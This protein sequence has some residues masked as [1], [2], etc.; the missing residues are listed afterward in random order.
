[1]WKEELVEI[2]FSSDP[3]K[4]DVKKA[5]NL[6]YMNTPTSLYRYRD[7]DD[8]HSLDLL[9]T[10]KLLLSK[11]SRFNDPFD[12]A[13]K[14]K[15]S[16]SPEYIGKVL[17]DESNLDYF[18][19]HNISLKELKK[20]GRKKD[21]LHELIKR[22]VKNNNP[23]LTLKERNKLIEEEENRIK[24]YN[25]DLGLKESIHLACFSE[26]YESILMWSHYAN[27]HEGFCVEYNFKELGLKSPVTRFI[28]PVI[29]TTTVFDM[30]DYIPDPN[31]KFEDVLY[32]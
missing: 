26:T 29:Y 25:L 14:L 1:M 28:F 5:I 2:L 11:P 3:S 7:F 20:A 10:D 16:D 21:P 13:L 6:K 27:N 18:K 24:G 9:K 30:K 8:G 23:D 32:G 4:L 17:A 15:V 31:K 19:K 12:C 22:Q